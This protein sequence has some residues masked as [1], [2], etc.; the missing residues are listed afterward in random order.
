MSTA[1]AGSAGDLR[2][3]D[4]V[5][6][7]GFGDGDVGRLASGPPGGGGVLADVLGDGGKAA[8]QEL[9]EGSHK[10][11]LLSGGRIE[12]LAHQEGPE[13]GHGDVL[14]G[15][16]GAARRSTSERGSIGSQGPRRQ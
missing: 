10:G 6:G 12:G 9:E 8:G 11:H 4:A 14:Q 15:R 16:G 2:G 3:E 13:E 7:R 1:A 5:D